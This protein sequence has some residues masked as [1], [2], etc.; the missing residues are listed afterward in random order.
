MEDPQ[1]AM[2]GSQDDPLDLSSALDEAEFTF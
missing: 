2:R 1:N